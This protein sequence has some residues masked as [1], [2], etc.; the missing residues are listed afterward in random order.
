LFALAMR[1]FELVAASIIRV[2][3]PAAAAL[4]LL[5]CGKHDRGQSQGAAL[6][7]EPS[8]GA[9]TVHP[10]S[11]I[12]SGEWRMPSGASAAAVGDGLSIT[13]PPSPRRE[14]GSLLPPDVPVVVLA[15]SDPIPPLVAA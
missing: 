9:G 5:S 10:V 13:L 12:S 4:A 7:S 6:A 11:E 14:A 8:H 2:V 3:I 15:A 1:R